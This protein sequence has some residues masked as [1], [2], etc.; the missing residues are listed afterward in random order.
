MRSCRGRGAVHADGEGSGDAED[1]DDGFL[2][3]GEVQL[4]LHKAEDDGEHHEHDGHHT[5]SAVG[6][7]GVGELRHAIGHGVGVERARDHVG[8]GRND[9]QAEQPAEQQ[10]QLPAQLADVFFNEHTHGLAFVLDGGIQCAKVRHSTEEH[11]A[12]QHPQQHRQPAERGGLNGAGDRA[13]S[14]DGGK[15]MAEDR[16][17]V[18][19][20]VILAVVVLNGGGLRFGVDAPFL[21]QPAAIERIGGDKSDRRDQHDYK[22]V[23]VIS[24][25]FLKAL[26]FANAGSKKE[27]LVLAAGLP[28]GS[29]DAKTKADP[30]TNARL[31][32]QLPRYHF[33]C[34][35]TGLSTAA[36]K[37]ESVPR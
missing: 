1:A 34:R 23:H 29:P 17:A 27:A 35:K 11:A 31:E 28:D 14:R 18:G 7:G 32:F 8:K 21:S 24:L 20:D 5:G 10:K 16:P 13:C 2:P 22:C 19:G 25:S 36:R 15:L 12:D 4:L 3:A 37:S 33:A 30:G 26:P 6:L 9:D